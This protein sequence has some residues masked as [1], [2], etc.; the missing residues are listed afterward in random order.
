MRTPDAVMT[1]DEISLC[2]AL[3]STLDPE[4]YARPSAKSV[5]LKC[6]AIIETSADTL[7]LRVR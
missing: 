4:R 2:I 1:E 5:I 6:R 7:T 3:V